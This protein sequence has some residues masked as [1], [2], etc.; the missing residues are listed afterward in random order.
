MGRELGH[1]GSRAAVL[2][3]GQRGLRLGGL[4]LRA[5]AVAR[6]ARRACEQAEGGPGAGCC[7]TCLDGAGASSE[8]TTVCLQASGLARCT[9][10]LQPWQKWVLSLTQKSAAGSA[11]QTWHR[12][13]LTCLEAG[14]GRQQLRGGCT[15]RRAARP[16][17]LHR[18]W[19]RAG[20]HLAATTVEWTLASQ[21]AQ[22][23]ASSA[24]QCTVAGDWQ[25]TQAA[26]TAGGRGALWGGGA[27]LISRNG[28]RAMFARV[29]VLGTLSPSYECPLGGGAERGNEQ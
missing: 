14:R 21:G 29:C 25:T 20:A 15:G 12:F 22:R 5:A 28:R 23:K 16:L 6:S 26:I 18:E 19:A 2:R 8:G 24:A 1:D 27:V 10:V 11:W 4:G 17:C 7:L 9:S 13:L 3:R